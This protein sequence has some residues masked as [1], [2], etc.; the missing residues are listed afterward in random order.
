MGHRK[1]SLGGL[2]AEARRRRVFRTAGLYIVGAWVLL[3]VAD[4][5]LESADLPS[6]LLR[7][8]WMAAFVGFP[9]A[10]IFGWYYEITPA[11][12]RKT[13]AADS[14]GDAELGLGVPDYIIV[15]ALAIVAAV[16]AAG[17]FDQARQA[18]EME[19]PYDPHGIAVLPLANLSGSE[20]Q[21]YFSAGMHDA[22]ITNLSR[23]SELRI[24]SRTS[25]ARLDRSLAMPAI[26]RQ[27]GVRN[28]IEGSVT[29]EGNRV[30]VIIQLI[31]A[32][33]DAQ[34]WAGNFEREF[35][36]VLALQN[37]MAMSVARAVDVRLSETEEALL[38]QAQEVDP[39]VYDAYL[40]GMYFLNQSDNQIRRKGIRILE[41]VVDGGGANARIY[42]ALA[43]GYA[44]L[45][46]SPYP[47]GMY[48]ASKEAARVA[49][50]LDDS[51]PELHLAIGMH[52]L[53]Y[54]WDFANAE[55]SL[56]RALELNPSLTGAHYHY[57]W[58]MEL[59]QRSDLSLPAGDKTIQ[60][61]PLSPSMRADLAAQYRNAGH[62]AQALELIQ[63]ALELQ[64]GHGWA[65]L[66]KSLTLYDMGDI[67][68]S[69]QAADEIAGHP[70]LRYQRAVILATTGR[71]GE[72]REILAGIDKTPS[73][74]MALLGIYA[75]LGD[76][77]EVF[78]WL[79]I[80]R[81]S[82]MVWYPFFITWYPALDELRDDPRMREL[83]EELGLTEALDR[84]LGWLRT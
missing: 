39:D 78:R 80:A 21:E 8:F 22:L 25:T 50:E 73:N 37:E 43:Y 72:A 16:V 27:L 4:L 79:E 46:H 60:L 18:S 53:Y 49:M 71:E 56:L 55:K 24:V 82:K 32:A 65:L 13:L 45:G 11:G 59:L 76:A 15:G 2:I 38:S 77:E 28:V 67:A 69:M 54:E 9:I 47:E 44:V 5:A 35:T 58:L 51:I 62:Y 26:G 41:G 40:R 12:I 70:L 74:L 20:G 61:D 19:G 36:S 33:E 64:P 81:D 7:Y 6:S 30:R 34:I 57:A 10:L 68:G 66:A 14:V 42:A 75:A 48:P 3:Q 23:I 31:D 63:E 52:H 1:H 83:A 84:S 29:R 17:L